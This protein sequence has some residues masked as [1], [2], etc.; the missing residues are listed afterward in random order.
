VRNAAGAIAAD[1]SPRTV[2]RMQF[3]GEGQN[4]QAKVDANLSHP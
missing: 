1:S 2:G 4:D 3:S